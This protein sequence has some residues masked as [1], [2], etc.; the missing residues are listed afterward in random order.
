MGPFHPSGA[1]SRTKKFLNCSGFLAARAISG[2]EEGDQQAGRDG[3]SGSELTLPLLAEEDVGLGD[4]SKDEDNLGLVGRVGSNGLGDCEESE[5][6]VR[7][8]E[9]SSTDPARTKPTLPEGSDAGSSSNQSNSLKLVGLVLELGDRSLDRELVS[10][11]ELEDVVGHDS[12]GVVLDEELKFTLNIGS[13]DGSV[14]LDRGLALLVESLTL[15]RRFD[16]E[17][18]SDSEAGRGAV[19]K[20]ESEGGGVVV[21]RGD[22]L[23]LEVAVDG[24]GRDPVSWFIPARPSES[25]THRNSSFERAAGPGVV[26][27]TLALPFFWSRVE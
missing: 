6:S 24:E 25:S 5:A 11:L 2:R 17:S 20:S 13:S 9:K 12:T 27:V 10:L 14:G 16:D 15:G 8:W 3:Q 18:R 4:I 7:R 19:G 22:L 26:V 23:E 1:L 21:V